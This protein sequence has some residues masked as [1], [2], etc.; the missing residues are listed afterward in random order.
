MSKF[1]MSVMAGMLILLA[2][3]SAFGEESGILREE[4]DEMKIKLERLEKAIE[5][6]AAID[7]IHLA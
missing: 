3:G 1:G 4:M 5:Q 6:Q 2:A 7:M